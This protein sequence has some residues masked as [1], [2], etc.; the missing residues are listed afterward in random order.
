MLPAEQVVAGMRQAIASLDPSLP[1]YGAGSVQAMLG[2]ALFPSQAAA[3]ALTAFGVL[4]LVLAATGIH[5]V[6]AYAVSKRQRE[7]GI[8]LAMGARSRDIL[9]VVLGR[10]TMLLA[11]G[12][13]IGLTLSIAAGRLLSSVVY[14]ASP[15]D[16]AVLAAVVVLF[17]AVGILSSWAPARRSLRTEPMRA[18]RP[19]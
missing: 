13:G 16:P 18:L 1:L 2:F 11:I 8:R 3:V 19:E 4:A 15:N 7:I 10:L 17:L 14:K 9:R 5:G 12:A 6:V